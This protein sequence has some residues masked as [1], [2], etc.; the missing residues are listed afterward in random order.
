MMQSH[1]VYTEFQRTGFNSTKFNTEENKWTFY[2][3]VASDTR[4]KLFYKQ[5]NKNLSET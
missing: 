5:N 2:I 3:F 1:K 4:R